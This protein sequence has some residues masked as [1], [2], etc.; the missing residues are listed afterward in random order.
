[1]A[2]LNY[3]FIAEVYDQDGNLMEGKQVEWSVSPEEAG[4]MTGDGTLALRRIEGLNEIT[5]T[6]RFGKKHGCCFTNLCL[7]VKPVAPYTQAEKID[8][9]CKRRIYKRGLQMIMRHR[10][11]GQICVLNFNNEGLAMDQT[12]LF[13]SDTFV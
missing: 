11:H 9:G 2:V 6:A 13:L 7:S 3:Q 8:E 4:S 1:M 10:N 5:L 12:D